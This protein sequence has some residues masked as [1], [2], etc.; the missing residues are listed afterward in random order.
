VREKVVERERQKESVSE[1]SEKEKATNLKKGFNISK[2]INA[3][4]LQF[5][6]RG[7]QKTDGEGKKVEADGV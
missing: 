5:E 2:Y 4:R 1:N 6:E 3:A 7:R